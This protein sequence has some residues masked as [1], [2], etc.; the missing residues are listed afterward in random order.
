VKWLKKSAVTVAGVALLAG[1]VALMVL[2]GPGILLVAAGLAVLATEYVWARRLVGKAK[3]GA[4]KAQQ[5]AVAS[6]PRTALTVS[7]AL[8]TMAVA[9][10]ML[11]VDDVGWPFLDSL[12][13]SVW[14][15]LTGSVLVLTSLVLLTTTVLAL[16][17]GHRQAAG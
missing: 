8:G 12:L 7:F 16:R 4:E 17:A 9:V 11:V 14:S 15:P 6:K 3:E 10:L 2:P 5:Q 13:D 1:G